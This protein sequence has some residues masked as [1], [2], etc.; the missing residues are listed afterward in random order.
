MA[1]EKQ[2]THEELNAL[3]YACG[4]VGFKLLKKYEKRS[5]KKADQFEM[6]LG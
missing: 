5:G 2:F 1:E 4:Y 3:R 6:C